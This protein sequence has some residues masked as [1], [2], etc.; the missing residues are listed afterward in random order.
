MVN[1]AHRRITGTGYMRI[2]NTRWEKIPRLEPNPAVPGLCPP[3][4]KTY[5]CSYF[6]V[7]QRSFAF[8]PNKTL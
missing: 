1:P 6:S 2:E 7:R 4:N 5:L 3:G 8:Q